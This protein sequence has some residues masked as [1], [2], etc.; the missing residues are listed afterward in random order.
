MASS[1]GK[2]VRPGSPVW[3]NK[4]KWYNLGRNRSF[5][6]RVFYQHRFKALISAM[7]RRPPL[8]HNNQVEARDFFKCSLFL[9]RMTIDAKNKTKP[10]HI[11][12]ETSLLRHKTEVRKN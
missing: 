11:L 2:K 12:M 7:L 1:A 9:T 10:T 4:L 6:I 8:S 5:T 3:E